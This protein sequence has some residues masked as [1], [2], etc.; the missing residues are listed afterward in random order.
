MLFFIF[1]FA[2]RR[3]LT[4]NFANMTGCFIVL[5]F[6]F[7]TKK[8]YI[9]QLTDKKI[10][11][12]LGNYCFSIYMMQEVMFC[13][14][15]HTFWQKAAFVAAHPVGTLVISVAAVCALGLATYYWVEKPALA[16]C[17]EQIKKWF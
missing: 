9:S 5:F 13:L 16:F 4:F 14:L 11:F 2:I 10:I 6:C 1:K 12:T 17:K 15:K 3:A 7:L 8:G